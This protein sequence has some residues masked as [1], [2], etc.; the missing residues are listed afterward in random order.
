MKNT[1]VTFANITN[2]DEFYAELLELHEGHDKDSS[3]AINAQLVLV[4]CNHIG[5]RDILRQ[6]FELVQ[7]DRPAS[8]SIN[9]AEA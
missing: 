5:N 9:E 4:L 3:D 1:L 8:R 2:P 6:A 7:I